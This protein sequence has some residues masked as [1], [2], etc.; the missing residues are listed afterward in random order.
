M[1]NIGQGTS[2]GGNAANSPAD[3]T[4]APMESRG[5]GGQGKGERRGT[6][7]PDATPDPGKHARPSKDKPGQWE[8][9]DPHTGKWVLKPPGWAPS[10]QQMIEGAAAIG[11]GYLIY[12]GVRMLPSLAPPLWWTIPE[13]LAIP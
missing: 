7:K 9:K 13:N 1:K 10:R 5:Q 3:Q 2:H 8:V 4:Q 12:R 6:G 11:T